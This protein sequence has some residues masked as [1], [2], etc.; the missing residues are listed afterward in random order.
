LSRGKELE[1]QGADIV[2]VGGESSRPGSEAVAGEEEMRRVVPVI[3]ALAGVLSIPVSVDTYRAAVARRSIEAGAQ[4]VNDISG[5]R[6]DPALPPLLRAAGAGVVLMHSRGPRAGIHW[7]PQTADPVQTVLDGLR[8]SIGTAES[9]GIEANAIVVDPGIGF[10]KDADASFKVL[11]NLSVFSSLRYPIL[12][13]T[14]RKS[15]I[16]AIIQDNAE[17][18]R[19]MG[20]A[21]TVAAAIGAGAHL[22]RVH[23]VAEMRKVADVMDRIGIA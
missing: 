5:F 10:S 3:E 19:L 23:D 12:V 22:V 4:I 16:R 9:H 14:S 11:K 8:E 18:A 6:F 15:F 17:E 2:D 7:Q 13:G 20:T 21:A 1:Q